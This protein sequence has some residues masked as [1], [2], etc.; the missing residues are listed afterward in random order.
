[1]WAISLCIGL[2]GGAPQPPNLEPYVA[3]N[4]AYAL[5]KPAGWTVRED[6][7]EDDLRILVRS[8]DGNS[9]V[10]FFFEKNASGRQDAVELLSGFRKRMALGC[11]E[12]TVSDAFVSRD[13][14]R[15]VAMMLCR[16]AASA[17]K[18]RYFFEAGAA[19]QSA[20]GY[21]TTEAA[22][23]AQ[24]PLLLNI[25]A[26]LSFA[27]PANAT[28]GRPPVAAPE[29]VYQAQLVPKRAQDGSLSIR[30]PADWTFLAGGGKVV[31]G[32]RDGGM[33][34]IFTSISGNPM[35]PNATIAQGILPTTYKPPAQALGLFLQAFGHRNIKILSASPDAETMQECLGAL[36][37]RCDAQDL[38]A[39]WTSSNGAECVGAIKMINLPPSGFSGIWNF[40]ISGIWGPENGF[41]RYYPM[42]KE[43]GESFAIND[44]FARRYIQQGLEN[45]RRLQAQTAAAM[46]DLNRAR[47]QNQ[48][49]WEARQERKD[50]MDS[51]W[52]DY[53]RGNSYWV[54][55]LE[56]GKIY[57]TDTHG[58]RDTVTGDY[59]GGQ[60][61]RWVNFEGQNPRYPSEN[62][63]ELSSWEVEHG[64]RPPK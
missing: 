62:M 55:D 40:I 47:E 29:P 1:V 18:G 2:Q 16:G 51:K 49:D 45:L 50:Y 5:H 34:F 7:T 8:A 12:L 15:A 13:G 20:Q 43:V 35:V 58:T 56:G 60:G 39:R 9:T 41:P 64:R 31:S 42:L 11:K 38:V 52:D 10:E 48:R 4:R 32:S 36:R 37:S 61:Y 63:R 54:S 17:V 21:L 33:G 14:A 27:R 25:L 57:Q 53:R 19:G 24:R 3:E 6:R 28:A 44:Q 22:M 30:I 59:Y 46:Q 26:S 23:Q